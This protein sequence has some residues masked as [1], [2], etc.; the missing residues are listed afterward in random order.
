MGEFLSAV[1]AIPLVRRLRTINPYDDMA[2]SIAS[3]RNSSAVPGPHLSQP[4]DPAF[5]ASS[6]T[7]LNLNFHAEQRDNE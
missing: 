4:I 7:P 3:A 2:W 1:V 6:C 5:D